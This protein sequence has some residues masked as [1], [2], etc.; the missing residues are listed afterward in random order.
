MSPIPPV[1]GA[2]SCFDAADNFET[3]CVDTGEIC[4]VA[5]LSGGDDNQDRLAELEALH[6]KRTAG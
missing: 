1:P 3:H 4:L 5:L 2:C 6:A